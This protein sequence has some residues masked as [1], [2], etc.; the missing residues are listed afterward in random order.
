MSKLK[1]WRLVEIVK[2]GSGIVP[3]ADVLAEVDPDLSSASSAASG[4]TEA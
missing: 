4:E 3:V 2:Q 1:R